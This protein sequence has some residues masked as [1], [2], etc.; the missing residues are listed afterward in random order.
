MLRA[1]IENHE[2]PLR[3]HCQNRSLEAGHGYNSVFVLVLGKLVL[4]RGN[5]ALQNGFF[6]GQYAGQL[7]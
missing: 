1:D 2:F 4:Q 6:V 7:F 3:I 5:V